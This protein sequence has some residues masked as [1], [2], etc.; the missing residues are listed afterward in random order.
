MVELCNELG[1]IGSILMGLGVLL[2]LMGLVKVI[3]YLYKLMYEDIEKGILKQLNASR[4]T[5]KETRNVSDT[6]YRSIRNKE[7]ISYIYNRLEKLEK[8]KRVRKKK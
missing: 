8:P 7:N 2:I 3:K 1:I 4:H 5:D 6:F